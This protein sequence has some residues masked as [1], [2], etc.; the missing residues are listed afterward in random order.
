MLV[1]LVACGGLDLASLQKHTDGFID[2]AW[3]DIFTIS[4]ENTA[5]HCFYN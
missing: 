3:T 2:S 5:W 4:I 1:V